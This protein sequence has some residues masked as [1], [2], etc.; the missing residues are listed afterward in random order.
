MPTTADAMT[1]A[2]PLWNPTPQRIAAANLTAFAAK[3]GARHGVDVAA[4]DAL[5]RWSVAHKATF[6]REVW[7]DVGVIGT[8]GDVVVAHE[9]RMPGAEWFPEASLNF[10]Q[11]LLERK[12]ADDTSD[13]LVFWGEE[14]MRRRLS[15]LELHALAARASAA[16]AAAGIAPGD[17]VA[18][19]LPNIPEAVI[20][21]LG[22][23]SRGATWSSC[24][25][26]F[27]VQGVLDRFGQI[28]PRILVTVDGYCYNGK[29]IPI[30][31][32]VAAIAAGLPSVEKVVV[33]PYLQQT[34]GRIGPSR[35]GARRRGVGCLARAV[36]ARSH[37]LCRV[38][39]RAPSL[40]PLFVGHHRRAEVHRAHGRRRAA[41]ASE[42]TPAARRREARRPDVLFHDLRVDDVE[43]AGLGAGLRRDAAA[44]RR[45]AVHRAGP[46]P[47]EVRRARADDALRHVGEVHRCAEEDRAGAAQGF[48][49]RAAARH[50]LDGQPVESRRAS[51]T[52]TSA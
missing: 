42:G 41:A 25:P 45:V 37:R 16:F 13:A 33:I 21:M 36:P 52:S 5:W 2:G 19:Y 29:V 38:A 23:T 24:S 40:H 46:H 22:A 26:E 43:L 12:R 4:Y 3:V 8:P 47:V 18:A 39:V 6:W 50:V 30:L 49:P 1:T 20:A 14:K 10:A 32:K 9:D 11:N 15:H 48:R 35:H 51:T 28:E 31:D 7:D 34:S 17:R 27:G 44:V